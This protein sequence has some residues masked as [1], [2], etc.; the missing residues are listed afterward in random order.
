M[1]AGCQHSPDAVRHM[2]RAL[3]LLLA[4][5]LP[6]AGALTLCRVDRSATPTRVP[7]IYNVTIRTVPECPED[8]YAV[9]RLASGREYPWEVL[10]PGRPFTWRGVPWYWRGQWVAE[11]GKIYTFKIPGLR[12]PWMWP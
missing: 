4:L 6:S 11:S 8:G 3:P 10:S 7:G 2:R 5:L 12:A 9:V 1:T